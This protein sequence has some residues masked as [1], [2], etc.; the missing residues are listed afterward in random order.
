[1]KY[2]KRLL[3]SLSGVFL[4][5]F[6]FFGMAHFFLWLMPSQ[7]LAFLA[8]LWTFAFGVYGVWLWMVK[9]EN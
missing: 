7:L 5:L 3:I 6:L 2:L 8:F 9:M 4:T 1:M